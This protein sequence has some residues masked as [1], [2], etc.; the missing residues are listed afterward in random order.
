MHKP[1]AVKALE[2]YKV[3]VKY[4]KKSKTWRAL[5]LQVIGGVLLTW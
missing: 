1:V 5:S 4:Q 2:K 3:W